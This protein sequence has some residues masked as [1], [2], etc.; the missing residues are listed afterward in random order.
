MD[1]RKLSAL[2][3]LKWNPFLEDIPVEALCETS[4]LCA[5]G[6][7]SREEP[8][9]GA[10]VRLHRCSSTTMAELVVPKSLSTTRGAVGSATQRL[11]STT[12]E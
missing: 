7:G 6:G 11:S 9:Q 8:S 4:V 10:P 5:R 12:N 2:Y 3:G 1:A